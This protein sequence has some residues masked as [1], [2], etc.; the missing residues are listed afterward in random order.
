MQVLGATL[1]GFGLCGSGFGGLGFRLGQG[2][3]ASGFGGC[4]NCVGLGHGGWISESM[5]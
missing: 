2:C 5:W 3:L 1:S 4:V